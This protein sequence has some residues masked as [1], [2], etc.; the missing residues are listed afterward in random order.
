MLIFNSFPVG[1]NLLC[2]SS[3]CAF[4]PF[5]KQET[6]YVSVTERLKQRRKNETKSNVNKNMRTYLLCMKKGESSIDE[7]ITKK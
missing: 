2:D 3:V 5:I 4:L 6:F 1:F 7:K